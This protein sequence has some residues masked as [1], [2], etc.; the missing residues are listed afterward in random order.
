M[1]DDADD[2]DAD[3]TTDQRACT[4]EVPWRSV[5]AIA[6][7]LC[8]EHGQSFLE[9]RAGTWTVRQAIL[10]TMRWNSVQI[11]AFEFNHEI[12]IIFIQQ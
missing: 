3:G 12:T 10:N 11:I 1:A 7:V 9:V 6:D 4:S 2:A 5:D 8:L